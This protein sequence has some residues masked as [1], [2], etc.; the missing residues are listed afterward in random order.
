MWDYLHFQSARMWY[1]HVLAAP[2]DVGSSLLA[3][4]SAIPLLMAYPGWLES[5]RDISDARESG[6][7][8]FG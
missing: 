7:D 4:A 8:L 6:D 5:D 2:A 3:I 1:R